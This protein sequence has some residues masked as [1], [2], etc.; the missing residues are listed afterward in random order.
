MFQPQF[1]VSFLLHKNADAV[2]DLPCFGQILQL[3]LHNQKLFLVVSTLFKPK[4]FDKKYYAFA[5]S[6]MAHD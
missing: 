2:D 6:P 1:F 3:F 5:V 4:F